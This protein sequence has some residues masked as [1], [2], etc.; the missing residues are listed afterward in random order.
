MKLTRAPRHPN[1]AAPKT[2]TWLVFRRAIMGEVQWTARRTA[3]DPA[4]PCA[5][6]IAV[7]PSAA[8]AISCVR[9]RLGDL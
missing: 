8:E 2:K 4:G 1:P 6:H 5:A 9:E 7:A 3:M